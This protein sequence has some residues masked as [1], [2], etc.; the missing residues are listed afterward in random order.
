MQE[1]GRFHPK[2]Q[3]TPSVSSRD[4]TVYNVDNQDFLHASTSESTRM[5]EEEF[6]YQLLDGEDAVKPSTPA[7]GSVSRNCRTFSDR[8]HGLA[9]ESQET[10]PEFAEEDHVCTPVSVPRHTEDEFAYQQLERDDAVSTSSPVQESM[11][12]T[13]RSLLD[14]RTRLGRESQDVTT[15]W[16]PAQRS[17]LRNYRSFSNRCSDLA[18]ELQEAVSDSTLNDPEWVEAQEW[19]DQRWE[20]YDSEEENEMRH[21]EWEEEADEFCSD[22]AAEM[23][24]DCDRETYE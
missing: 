9:H 14:Q 10:L 2:T 3:T 11:S 12:C 15:P 18:S 24:Q 22:D 16:P 23:E 5:E 7:Q 1:T 20:D 17:V 19:E 21:G 13:R 8:H 4:D 6:A